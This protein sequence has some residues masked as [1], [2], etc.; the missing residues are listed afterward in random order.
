LNQLDHETLYRMR[1]QI[2]ASDPK[3]R[4]LALLEHQAFAREWVKENPLNAL[5]LLFAVPAY[6]GAKAIGAVKARTPASWDEIG[7][8]YRGIGE[9]LFGTKGGNNGR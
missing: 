9:G 3:Q 6:T 7:A 8:G 1:G 2:P 4:D 5:S